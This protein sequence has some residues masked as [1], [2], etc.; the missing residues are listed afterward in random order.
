MANVESAMRRARPTT[1]TS[2]NTVPASGLF[3]KKD[4]GGA[5]AVADADG[6]ATATVA[7]TVETC[8]LVVVK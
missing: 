7:V 5:C 8:P 6:A 3:C 1:P 4:F 2:A